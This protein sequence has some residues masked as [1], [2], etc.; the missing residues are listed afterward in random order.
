[1]R[2]EKDEIF[3][4]F[5]KMFHHFYLNMPMEIQPIEVVSM[6]QYKIEHHPYLVLFLRERRSSSLQQMFTDAKEIEDNIRA[7]GRLLNRVLDEDL[8]HEKVYE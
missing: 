2:R 1:L 7:H 3:I 5:N 8:E 6:V 4:V